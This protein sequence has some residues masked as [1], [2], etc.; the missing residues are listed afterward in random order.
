MKARE[1]LWGDPERFPETVAL[2][3]YMQE[4]HAVPPGEPP[5]PPTPHVD[6]VFHYLHDALGSVI[7]LVD[8]AGELVE[9]Y[10]YDPYGKVFIETW[11]PDANEGTGAWLPSREPTSGLPHSP[12]GNPFLWTGQRYDASSATYGFYARSYSPTL[13]RFIQRDPL[14]YEAG[15]VNLYEYVL[16]A[17]L[18]WVDP[19]GMQPKNGG[20]D[21]ALD[22]INDLKNGPKEARQELGLKTARLVLDK[23][24]PEELIII[25]ACMTPIPG[26]EAAAAGLAVCKKHVGKFLGKAKK[27]IRKAVDKVKEI[28]KRSKKIDP[29]DI[30]VCPKKKPSRPLNKMGHAK[31][32]AEE[33]R[34]LDPSLDDDDIANILEDVVKNGTAAPGQHGATVYTSQ[35]QIG[36]QTVTVKVVK[37]S[38]GVIKTGFPVY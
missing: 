35:V 15:S 11:D 26:D 4:Y 17:P 36:G 31:R 13:G 18:F 9:R 25:G 33:F 14:E 16:S 23:T 28:F 3:R 24:E 6:G 10:T 38:G 1:F 2:V 20:A 12:V 27:G 19:L 22:A 7:G 30:K 34:E 37:S 21:D 32:H 5:I 8:A 29:P